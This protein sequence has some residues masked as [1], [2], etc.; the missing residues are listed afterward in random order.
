MLIEFSVKNFRSIND[1]QTLS[2]VAVP[3]L[4]KK[5]NT[6]KVS[7]D[8]EPN[9]PALLKVIA[10]YGPNASG[11]S[12][13]VRSME[14]LELMC[15]EKPSVEK[16]MLPISPFRF[17]PLLAD[18]PSSFEVHFI[19][20]RTRYT[21]EIALT[22]ERVHEER[23]TVYKKGVPCELYARSFIGG[24]EVYRFDPSLEGG[25][26][27]HE[28][29]RKLT[30]PQTLFIAQ[31]VANSNEELTQ[32]KRP[33][34]WLSGL[35][36]ESDGMRRSASITRKLIADLPD[37]GEDVAK[38]LSDVDIPVSAIQ[39]KLIREGGGGLTA[40]LD[41]LPAEP[42]SDQN[43]LSRRPGSR[44]TT[45]LTHRTSLGEA[46]F[47]FEEES[48]GTKNLI[49]FALPWYLFK[50]EGDGTKRNVLVVDELDTSL[51]PKL[52][53]SLVERHLQSGLD[54]QLIF[55]THDTHLMDAKLLRRDQIWMTERD[56]TGATQLRSVHDFEGRE[57]EDIEKRYYEGR[58][59]ALPIV[60]KDVM[61]GSDS[62]R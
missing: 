32:L 52:V 17:D 41:P 6:I 50:H 48:D 10:I 58:Y 16:R 38:L 46:D 29:W 20:N 7:V 25:D 36:V 3:R 11:K 60:K 2:M 61:N 59:R 26:D 51:H 24:Q 34:N 30:G 15:R 1:R 14:V 39:S 4:R 40:L 9:F 53:E 19:Q 43:L 5:E 33:F 45:T 55:T 12:N 27:L 42:A 31:A 49:G 56:R 22:A 35:M 37:F 57:G 21:F 18:K 44:F 47:D 23:L 13:L 54:H 8:G 28:A 62:Y